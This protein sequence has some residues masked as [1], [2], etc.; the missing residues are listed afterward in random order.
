MT[1][2]IGCLTL[3]ESSGRRS[4]RQGYKAMTKESYSIT[5]AIIMRVIIRRGT[6]DRAAAWEMERGA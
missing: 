3:K 2:S 6:S 1:G 4:L 5:V